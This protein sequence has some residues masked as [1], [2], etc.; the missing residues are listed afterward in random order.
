MCKK[1]KVYKARLGKSPIR[2]ALEAANLSLNDVKQNNLAIKI[3][4][5]IGLILMTITIIAVC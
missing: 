3:G 1:V 2:K 5:V 4:I